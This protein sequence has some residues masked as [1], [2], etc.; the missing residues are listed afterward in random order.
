MDHF[1]GL[2]SLLDLASFTWGREL[3]YFL[4]QLIEQNLAVFFPFLVTKA[5]A[6]HHW[7]MIAI[8]ERPCLDLPIYPLNK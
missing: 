5:S 6:W 7:Q 4:A 2:E 8:F 1:F 3:T